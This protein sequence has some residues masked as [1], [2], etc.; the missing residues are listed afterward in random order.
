MGRI[1]ELLERGQLND[2]RGGGGGGGGRERERERERARRPCTCTCMAHLAGMHQH[3]A[4]CWL[5]DM[6]RCPQAVVQRP[7]PAGSLCGVSRLNVAV[8]RRL[9]MKT[10][11]AFPFVHSSRLESQ[12]MLSAHR[13]KLAQLSASCVPGPF[14]HS[15][16]A[17]SWQ[18]QRSADPLVIGLWGFP[19]P[20]LPLA[21]GS[22]QMRPVLGRDAAAEHAFTAR[23]GSFSLLRRSF[24]PCFGATLQR[25]VSGWCCAQGC[26]VFV[27]F[28]SQGPISGLLALTSRTC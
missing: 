25:L 9:P 23:L 14:T 19:L 12:H 21:V 4:S 24:L 5:A 20:R 11:Q 10:A 28:L 27:T 18:Q 22:V 7:D 1:E 26:L 15:L 13:A 6:I 16:Q 17:I 2:E 8:P 3:R